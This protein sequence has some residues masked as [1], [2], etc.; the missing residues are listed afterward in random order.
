MNE[1]LGDK[2]IKVGGVNSGAAE[3]KE[4]NLVKNVTPPKNRTEKVQRR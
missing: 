1:K 4:V 2:G 3:G